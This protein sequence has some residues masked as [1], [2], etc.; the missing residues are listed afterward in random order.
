MRISIYRVY[1]LLG[2]LSVSSVL[3]QGNFFMENK[4]LSGES[5]EKKVV[6]IALIVFY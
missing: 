2:P 1:G 4:P 6:M 5:F 3:Y